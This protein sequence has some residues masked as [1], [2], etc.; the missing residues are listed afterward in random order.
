MEAVADS[1]TGLGAERVLAVDLDPVAVEVARK[2]LEI[3][4]LSGVEFRVAGADPEA[5]FSEPPF[6]LVLANILI[7]LPLS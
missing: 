3:N 2:N 6:D 1:L 5:V 7:A 4:G